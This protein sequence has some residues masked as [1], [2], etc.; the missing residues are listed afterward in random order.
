[1]G[2]LFGFPQ[3]ELC[4]TDGHV[5]TMFHEILY[6]F[7]QREQ[8]RTAFHQSDAVHGESTLQCGHLE[9]FV[10]DDLG[11]GVAFHVN[12]NA[13]TLSA[14]LVVGV[15]DAF[16]LAIL[17]KV[18]DI[19]D[20]LSFVHAIRYLCDD[21]L[22]VSFMTLDLSLSTHHDTSTTGLVG[23]LHT[24]QAIDIGTCGEVRSLYILHE[25]IGVD[26]RIIDISTTTVNHLTEIMCR[27][28]CG[29]THSNTVAAIYQQVRYLRRHDGRLCQR[30]VEVGSHI[31][32]FFLQ[33]VHDVLTH[34]RQAT[35]CVSH[36]SCR[37]A[38]N[39]T[40]VSLS[41]Y[42]RV[43]HVPILGHTYQRSINGAVAVGVVLTQHF[44]HHAGT[45]LVRLVA[46]VAD[47]SHTVK[48]TAVHGFETI[49]HIGQSTSH[50]HRH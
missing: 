29:H 50:N 49:A 28:V 34:L 22:I 2:A 11:I 38:I 12:D 35:L 9:Q 3:V 37:V 15:R 26:V 24:L 44:T 36:C 17:Y 20:E 8:T 41:V 13:H 39:T 27:Y 4:A 40:E 46:R 19:L 1:M 30:I 43:A 42:Q 18:G 48:D 31:H 25:S 45:F 6:A 47:A 21:N 7:L 23:I 33:I 14:R 16:E 5:V 32:R 10:Q